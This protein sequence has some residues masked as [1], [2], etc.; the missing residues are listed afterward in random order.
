[1]VSHKIEPIQQ[2]V[3]RF[4][5]K[6]AMGFMVAVELGAGRFEKLALTDA[7]RR[8]GIELHKPYI[9]AYKP[10]ARGLEAIH[11][12]MLHYCRLLDDDVFCG[13]NVVMLI[14]SLEHV[15]MDQGRL[16][17]QALIS[18]FDKILVVTPDGFIEQEH[19]TWGMGN[20]YQ[21]HLSGWNEHELSRI[22]FN[23]TK[24]GDLLFGVFQ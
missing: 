22:G 16:L 7:E 10:T 9:D 21:R 15:E 14:D 19:D 17:L 11:G 5:E 12:N 4:I 1:M 24:R 8:I 23:V 13:H 6:E 20:P 18:S 3:A 2:D